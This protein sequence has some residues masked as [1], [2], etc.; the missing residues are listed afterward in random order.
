MSVERN[1]RRRSTNKLHAR[2][3][4]SADLDVPGIQ[5]YA[6]VKGIVVFIECYSAASAT[7]DVYDTATSTFVRYFGGVQ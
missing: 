4:C 5:V 3:V 6:D 1:V 7:T 2:R